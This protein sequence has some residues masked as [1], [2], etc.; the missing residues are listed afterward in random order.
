MDKPAKKIAVENLGP[1]YGQTNH[2]RIQNGQQ[3]RLIYSDPL[4]DLS[5]FQGRAE[6]ISRLNQWLSD[7]ARSIIGILGEGGIGKSS[8]GSKVFAECLGFDGKFRGDIRAGTSITELA[9]RALMEFGVLPEQVQLIEDVNLVPRLLRRLQQGRYLFFIDNL[10]SALT[11]EGGWKDGY[12]QFFETF[13]DFGSR[14]V[15]LLASREYPPQYYSWRK[16]HDLRLNQGLTPDEGAALLSSLE[17]EDAEQYG[18]DV[19]AQVQGHPLALSLIAGWIG[20]FRPG[21]RSLK[22]LDSFDDLFELAGRHRGEHQIS[23]DRVLEWSFERLS[24]TSQFLLAQVSVLRGGFNAEIAFALM[25]DDQLSSADEAFSRLEDLE[26]RSLVQQLPECDRLGHRLFQLQPRIKDFIQKKGDDFTQAHQLAI[27]YFWGSRPKEF[28]P[29]DGREAIFAYEETFYHQY[30]LKR[31]CDAAQ[32]VSSC[33]EFLDRHGFYQTIVELYNLLCSVWRPKRDELSTYSGALGNLGLAYRS[34]GQYQKSIECQTQSLEL[35]RETGDRNGEAKSL[36]NLA[37]AFDSSG[38]YQKAIAFQEQSLEIK[39]EIGDRNGEANSLG[40]LGHTFF[41]LGQYQNAIECQMQSLEINREMGDRNGAA[42]SLG[43]L[44]NVF[45][46]L[47]QYQNAIEC[48][49]QSLEINR[50]MGDR[51]G[52][53]SSLGNLGNAFD[54][55]GQFQRAIEFYSQSLEITREIGDRNGEATSLGNLGNVFNTLGQYQKAID[56][57]EQ[58]LEIAREIGDRIGEATYIANLGSAFHAL[59]QYQKAIEYYS[60]SLE[61]AREIGARNVKASVIGN[62]GIAF[63]SLGQYRKA[64][65]YHSQHNKIVRKIGDRNGEANSL[66]SLGNAFYSLEGV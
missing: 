42:N 35:V 43:N 16:F 2:V 6:Q 15:V 22:Q 25:V 14:S 1:V 64:I 52:E 24:Q 12:D 58:S 26:R 40:N 46:A 28:A 21:Q 48:Q 54:A 9:R 41:S 34:L 44:G 27:S 60:H 32:T 50:E 56:F 18:T 37:L 20:Q 66:G 61:I 29:D 57:Q 53:A 36:G 3:I 19:S 23:V 31:F 10:E 45:N 38:K 51:S 59:G 63:H 11:A 8:L 49:M 33:E 65:K 5:A 13:Q 47:G 62:L 4:P 55:L 17:V 39:R 30:Q 7:E